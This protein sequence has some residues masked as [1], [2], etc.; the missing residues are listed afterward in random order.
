MKKCKS[1]GVPSKNKMFEYYEYQLKCL[2]DKKLPINIKT[3][4]QLKD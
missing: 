4:R 3:Y 1:C 2:E